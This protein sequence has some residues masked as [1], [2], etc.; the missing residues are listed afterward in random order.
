VTVDPRKVARA[1]FEVLCLAGFAGAVAVRAGSTFESLEGIPIRLEPGGQYTST[2][3][4][5]TFAFYNVQDGIYTVR[6][7]ERGLPPEAQVT[8]DRA[9]QV[10]IATGMS[11][12]DIRFELERRRPGEKPVRRVLET[13]LSTPSLPNRNDSPSTAGV[14]PE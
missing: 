1:D 14:D 10:E 3:K 13:I 8:G 7:D 12:P 11:A 6:I 5:G 4:D 2:A 9:L